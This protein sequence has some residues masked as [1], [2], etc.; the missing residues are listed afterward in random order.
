MS[1]EDV[2]TTEA[3]SFSSGG[4]DVTVTEDVYSGGIAGFNTD[5]FSGGGGLSG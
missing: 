4:T 1:G 5:A 2:V 3:T